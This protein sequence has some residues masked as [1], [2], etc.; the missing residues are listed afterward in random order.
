MHLQCCN[1]CCLLSGFSSKLESSMTIFHHKIIGRRIHQTLWA[2]YPIKVSW[3][4]ILANLL[5]RSV[6]KKFTTVKTTLFNARLSLCGPSK[7]DN[8]M[9]GKLRKKIH[10]IP[11]LYSEGPHRWGMLWKKHHMTLNSIFKYSYQYTS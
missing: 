7:Y 8:W 2:F 4:T 9:L 5:F 1:Y 11:L 3:K 10:S 6:I